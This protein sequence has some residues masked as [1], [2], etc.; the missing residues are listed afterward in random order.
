MQRGAA[1]SLALGDLAGGGHRIVGGVRGH[2][3]DRARGG[4]RARRATGAG[5]ARRRR[6]QPLG[7][8]ERVAAAADGFELIVTCP[9]VG[10]ERVARPSVSACKRAASCCSRSARPYRAW[11]R[12]RA[13]VDGGHVGAGIGQGSGS[14]GAQG[15][16][17]R[18][19]SPCAAPG[20]SASCCCPAPTA[21]SACSRAPTR[22]RRRAGTREDGMSD[23]A[24]PRLVTLWCPEWPT[25]AARTPPCT[26]RRVPRQLRDRLHAGRPRP[27]ATDGAGAARRRLPA[28]TVVSSATTTATASRGR[29]DRA[30]DR[31]DGTA[32]PRSSNWGGCPSPPKAR[33]YFGGDHPLAA[34]IVTVAGS[35]CVCPDRC[36]HR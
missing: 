19:R 33:R 27:R 34:R 18:H 9:P 28:P 35:V 8:V 22:R 6:R 36:R 16:G 10:A 5:R 30:S 17:C 15:H 7:V 23:G 4:E 12:R 13:G 29:A 26:R 11:R 3:G 32:P 21:G 2:A 20:A 24:V 14:H 25:V 1:W 31:R